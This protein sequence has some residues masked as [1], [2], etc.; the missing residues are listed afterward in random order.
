VLEHQIIL[1]HSTG[2]SHGFVFGTFDS[3][4]TVENDLTHGKIWNFGESR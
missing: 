3:E 2:R 1:D 4:Q